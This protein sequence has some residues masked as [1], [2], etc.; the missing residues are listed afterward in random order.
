MACPAFPEY[1]PSPSII[2]LYRVGGSIPVLF[3]YLSEF[4]RTKY[5]GPYLGVQSTFWMIGRLLCGAFAWIIIPQ[6]GID[7]SM[8]L[9]RF[10]S[11]RLFLIVSA[12]PSL[13]GVV[14]Y[15]FLPE[16]P[17]Y[18]LEVRVC[19]CVCVCVC[20]CVCVLC[21]CVCVCVNSDDIYT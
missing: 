19:V 21:V 17:R 12:I 14:L 10:H 5:R 16:S 7:F 4:I 9:F 13:L 3:P 8:G 1:L 20:A 2:H 15:W 6:T 11:W 18:L